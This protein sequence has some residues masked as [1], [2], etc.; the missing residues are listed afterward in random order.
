[1]VF[2][3]CRPFELVT[4]LFEEKSD[5]ICSGLSVSRAFITALAEI[6][7]NTMVRLLGYLENT[8]GTRQLNCQI[9]VVNLVS[10]KLFHLSLRYEAALEAE[11]LFSQILTA[12]V[13]NFLLCDT[14]L[15]LE[16]VLHNLSLDS[17]LRINSRASLLYLFVLV[18]IILLI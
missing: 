15:L 8:L 13:P 1:M 9:R 10:V 6:T 7:V 17:L 12:V 4:L 2:W 5:A 3:S 11:S 14:L 18:L 16:P